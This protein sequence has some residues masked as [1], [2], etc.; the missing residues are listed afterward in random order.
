MGGSDFQDLGVLLDS[1][2]GSA[3]KVTVFYEL[4]DDAASILSGSLRPLPDQYLGFSGGGFYR[5]RLR[6]SFLANSTWGEFQALAIDDIELAGSAAVP[7][8]GTLALL[9]LG[10]VGLGLGRRRKAG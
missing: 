10:L 2:F 3:D 6:T 9:G 5:V 8:P 7:E 1:G 4:F